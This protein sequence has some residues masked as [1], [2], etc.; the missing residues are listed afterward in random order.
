MKAAQNWVK[1]EEFL[2]LNDFESF[3][4]LLQAELRSYLAF[5]QL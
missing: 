4:Q 5:Y 2:R 1:N 3:L